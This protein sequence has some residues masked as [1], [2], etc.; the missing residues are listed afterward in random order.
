MSAALG[1][2]AGETGACVAGR[3]RTLPA[4]TDGARLPPELWERVLR[5]M[6]YSELCACACTCRLLR[7]LGAFA[8]SPPSS[9]TVY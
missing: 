1:A 3:A 5:E 4:M 9:F 6:D 8:S 2:A 7:R